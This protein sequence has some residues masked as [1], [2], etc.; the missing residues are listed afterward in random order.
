MK[1][2]FYGKKLFDQLKKNT[3]ENYN[4]TTK[5]DKFPKKKR[6]SAFLNAEINKIKDEMNELPAYKPIL[7][8][9]SKHKSRT[10]SVDPASEEFVMA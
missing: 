6:S 3:V 5:V 2:S 4:S 7:V 8:E 10:N 1:T 9:Q